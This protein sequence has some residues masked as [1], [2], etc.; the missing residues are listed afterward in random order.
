VDLWGGYRDAA[1]AR[2][3]TADTVV[4][5]MSVS[6]IASAISIFWL[7]ERGVLDV[8]E[9]VA[10]Y[11][12]EFAAGD[13]EALPLQWVLDHR[14]GLAVLDPPSGRGTIY[15]H[16]EM[17]AA[18]AAQRPLWTPGTQAGYHILTQGFILAEVIRRTDGRTLGNLFAEE[19]A[20]PLGIDYTIGLPDSS[21][22]R[23]AEFLM[24]TEGTILDE[25]ARDPNS[26]QGRAWHQLATGEDFNSTPWRRSEIPSAN[27]HGNARAVARLM[28]T[29]AGGGTLDGITV[30]KPDTVQAMSA[31][32]HNLVEVVMNRSYH[33]ASGVLRNSP[34]LV[35]MGP[36][37]NAFGHHGVGGAL[38][39][40][41]PDAG[42]GFS[43]GMNRMHSRLDNGPRAARLL[44]A[45]Y[46]ALR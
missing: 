21:E 13:K 14:A 24:A 39:V 2:I 41:D 38:G 29:L 22:S 45:C 46:E 3:W 12:P 37:P 15:D 36:N 40:A 6:K 25:A 17:A 10:A 35:W 30:L 34:P 20:A 4:N 42:L 18:L 1:H 23:C 27:G 33:Q 9:P 5:M 26:W 8:D 32:Q 7:V 16:A 19:I 44:A 28:A 31:E 43:Y 11:W